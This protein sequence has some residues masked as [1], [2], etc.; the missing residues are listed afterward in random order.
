MLNKAIQAQIDMLKANDKGI[1]V[2][3]RANQLTGI[4]DKLTGGM[5]SKVQDA[6]KHVKKVGKG[7]AP[8]AKIS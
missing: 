5:V 2:Q 1:K 6:R 4:G 8:H 3:N 7:F